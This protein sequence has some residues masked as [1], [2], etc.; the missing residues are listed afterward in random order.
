MNH[1]NDNMELIQKMKQYSETASKGQKQIALYLLDI[2]SLFEKNSVSFV[3]KQ[4]G[5]SE[6]TL[7]R[8]FSSFGYTKLQDFLEQV[9]QEL[10]INEFSSLNNDSEKINPNSYI[11]KNQNI[12][13]INTVWDYSRVASIDKESINETMDMLNEDAMMQALELLAGASKVYILGIRG[14][15]PVAMILSYYLKMIGLETVLINTSDMNEIFE[16]MVHIKERDL[17]FAISFADYSLRTLRALEYAN[18]KKASII[19]LTDG[20][21]SPMNMYSSC[22]LW[23]KIGQM[24]IVDSMTAPLS[25]IY[26]LTAQLADRL[27][28]QVKHN[29]KQLE[30][31]WEN[32][33]VYGDDNL[34]AQSMKGTDD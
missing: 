31:V 28:E 6:K 26:S 33:D 12:N 8:F 19:T 15:Y 4:M 17:F 18:E 27:G 34:I 13:S 20:K 32:N 7:K 30:E 23:A 21:Y 14:C 1:D 29:I 2:K 3:S 25:V 5:V 24:S 9:Y 22:N 10:G 11:D 16:Q